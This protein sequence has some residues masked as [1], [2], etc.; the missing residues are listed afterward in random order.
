MFRGLRSP[1]R[2]CGDIDLRRA[3]LVFSLLQAGLALPRLLVAAAAVYVGG[4]AYLALVPGA[5]MY[6]L[7]GWAGI[8]A[9]KDRQRVVRWDSG[10]CSAAKLSTGISVAVLA[11]DIA[12]FADLLVWQNVNNEPPEMV[13]FVAAHQSFLIGMESYKLYVFW[14]YYWCLSILWPVMPE[15]E[16]DQ[17]HPS[18]APR[19]RSCCKGLFSCTAPPCS[20]PSLGPN[21][22]PDRKSG[23]DQIPRIP[24]LLM[25]R[26]QCCR[27]LGAGKSKSRCLKLWHRMEDLVC[28]QTLLTQRKAGS[29][30][31]NEGPASLTDIKIIPSNTP[32]WRNS[33]LDAE[34]SE[35]RMP[36]TP[37]GRCIPRDAWG[38]GFGKGHEKHMTISMETVS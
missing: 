13:A 35:A 16:K 17:C 5:L 38:V 27:G 30:P 12:L 20:Q 29:N 25:F 18:W 6:A 24:I 15:Q 33:A 8:R 21:P 28:Q 31:L 1:I 34:G 19:H 11:V 23:L 26:E 10:I 9:A 4:S 7:A 22:S 36:S 32:R 37:R 14:T 2:C 3:V